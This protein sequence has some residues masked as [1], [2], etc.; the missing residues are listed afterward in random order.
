MI[1]ILY[2]LY[3]KV[4]K[5]HRLSLSGSVIAKN[6]VRLSDPLMNFSTFHWQSAQ[7]SPLCLSFFNALEKRT[8]K[9]VKGKEA[10]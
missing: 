3:Q 7:Q 5:A 9:E 10:K 2:P 8:V 1:F 6:R 4:L